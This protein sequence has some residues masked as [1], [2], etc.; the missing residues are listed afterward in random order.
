MR[1]AV[2]QGGGNLPTWGCSRCPQVLPV[3]IAL[4]LPSGSH[5]PQVHDAGAGRQRI[6]LLGQLANA[7]GTI[8]WL[9]FRRADVTS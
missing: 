4:A 1:C 9:R 3:P 2:R 6:A 7:A 5:T 8:A